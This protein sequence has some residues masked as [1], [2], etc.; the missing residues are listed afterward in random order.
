MIKKES[1]INS[2]FGRLT[3][4]DTHI[5]DHIRYCKCKCSCGNIKIIRYSHLKNGYTKSCGCLL[6]DNAKL[7][8]KKHG[9][10][11]H[12][13]SAI[14]NMMKQ[15]CYNKK[16][17]VYKDYGGRDIKV[18]TEWKND[19]TTFYN[20]AIENGYKYGL[21]I[22]RINVDGDYEPNNCRFVTMKVQQNNRRNNIIVNFNGNS[23][24]LSEWSK[25]LNIKPPTIYKRLFILGWSIEKAFTTKVK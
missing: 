4:L 3:V 1:L 13:L 16:N 6:V 21:T 12:P 22:D 8:F 10:S 23:K 15:R 18:C 5:K 19:F 25:E 2:K 11:K 24:T 9:K 7:N 14:W 17:R 20:W